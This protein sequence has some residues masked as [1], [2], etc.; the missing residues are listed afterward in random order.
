MVDI[1][2]AEQPGFGDMYWCWSVVTVL[3]SPKGH[4]TVRVE[5]SLRKKKTKTDVPIVNHPG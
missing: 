2:K 1:F 4:N 3:L 5:T